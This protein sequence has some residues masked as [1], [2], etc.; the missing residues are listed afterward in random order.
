MEEK[1]ENQ[2]LISPYCAPG[3]GL[4][5]FVFGTLITSHNKLDMNAILLL[6]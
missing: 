5:M 3:T 2:Q 1:E 6:A 4:E